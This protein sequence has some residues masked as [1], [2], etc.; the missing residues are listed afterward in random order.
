MYQLAKEKPISAQMAP[1]RNP[2][3]SASSVAIIGG[4]THPKPGEISLAH[5]GV[6]FLDKI[7]EFTKKT[8]DMLRQP[9]ETEKVTISR[10]HSTVTYPASFILIGAMNPCPCGY[11]GSNTHYCTCTPKQ[12]QA[13]RNRISGPVYDRMDILLS[14]QPVDISRKKDKSERSIEIRRRIEKAQERQFFR[15]QKQIYNSNIPFEIL[16]SQ[17][18]LTSSQQRM[19]AQI[20][21]KQH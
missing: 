4:G 10:A 14:L 12:I 21:T 16:T 13:Y 17:S 18:P 2:H 11:L 9:L 6:L 15:Y 20:S 3:H 5:H 7:A 19:I 8:L 1:F